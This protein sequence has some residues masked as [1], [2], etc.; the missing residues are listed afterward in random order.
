MKQKCIKILTITGGGEKIYRIDAIKVSNPNM[1]DYQEVY[2][3][4][5]DFIEK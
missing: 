4:G 5:K 3:D 2:E 1:D